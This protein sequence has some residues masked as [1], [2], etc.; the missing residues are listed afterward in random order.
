[1]REWLLAYEVPVITA[2]E[3]MC[4]Q[5]KGIAMQVI[6]DKQRDATEAL[7]MPNVHDSMANRD[8][9]DATGSFV[10]PMADELLLPQ[11]FPVPAGCDVGMEEIDYE[12]ATIEASYASQFKD[13]CL[14]NPSEC[15]P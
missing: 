12:Q 11:P 2:D 13:W 14:A 5:F 4:N 3:A 1:M 6:E 7:G 15:T 8:K 9:F 10:L